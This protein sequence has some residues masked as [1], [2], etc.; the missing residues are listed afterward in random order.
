MLLS[1]HLFLHIYYNI[2]H[3]PRT[4]HQPTT[5]HTLRRWASGRHQARQGAPH[6]SARGEAR[7]SG[8]CLT[9][10]ENPHQIL[11]FYL[12]SLDQ[13]WVFKLV[14]IYVIRGL[15]FLCFYLITCFPFMVYLILWHIHIH[16]SAAEKRHRESQH[17]LTQERHSRLV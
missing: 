10:I 14:Y 5:H 15:F 12:F 2:T 6:S 17:R 16:L 1:F 3:L 8:R 7:H 11:S 9:P 13:I 4:T